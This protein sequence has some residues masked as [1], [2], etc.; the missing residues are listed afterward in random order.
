MEYG[1]EDFRLKINMYSIWNR[2]QLD[3]E[4]LNVQKLDFQKTK[5][6]F[7]VIRA[8]NI[9]CLTRSQL[10]RLSPPPDDRLH[11]FSVKVYCNNRAAGLYLRSEKK[12]LLVN[13]VGLQME[14]HIEK[15]FILDS[16][17]NCHQFW[18]TGWRSTFGDKR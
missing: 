7:V 10:D 9:S 13:H 4:L 15:K 17:E 14:G 3:K 11:Y 18:T 1:D 5:V 12:R 2:F 8:W 16:I 6:T